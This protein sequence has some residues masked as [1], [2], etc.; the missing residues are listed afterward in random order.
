MPAIELTSRQRQKLKSQAHHLEP[1]VMVG[2]AGIT[3]AVLA[4]V[5]RALLDHEL[6]KVQLREPEDKKAMAEEL[7]STCSA[8]LCGLLGHT[9]ILYRPHPERPR[10]QLA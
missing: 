10:I 1:V 9:V 2:K 3:A 7:A 5:E 8:C 6:I 4:S